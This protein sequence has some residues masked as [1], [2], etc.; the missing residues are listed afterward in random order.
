MVFAFGV[1]A[2]GGAVCFLASHFA[3]WW[4]KHEASD[5]LRDFVV[6]LL[7]LLC[8][9]R[10]FWIFPKGFACALCVFL[11]GCQAAHLARQRGFRP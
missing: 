9:L 4:L 1:V 8:A 5:R 10:A 3:A 2:L 11:V 7:V 6:S